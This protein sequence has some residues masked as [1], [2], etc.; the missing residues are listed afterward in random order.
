MP[1]KPDGRIALA[2]EMYREGMRPVDIAERLNLPAGTVRRW[3]CTYGWERERPEEKV[4]VRKDSERS[5][6]QANVRK[7]SECSERKVN[8]RKEHDARSDMKRRY[9]AAYRRCHP[10][11]HLEG[12]TDEQMEAQVSREY[13]E[14]PHRWDAIRP[15]VSK[16][17][18]SGYRQEKH[19]YLDWMTDDELAL[20]MEY[21]REYTWMKVF[22]STQRWDWIREI[23]AGVYHPAKTPREALRRRQAAHP[24]EA[25]QE[26]REKKQNVQKAC[27]IFGWG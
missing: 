5:Q 11:L 21:C 18:L 20:D 4:N 10:H 16:V 22:N 24:E 7:D 13:G 19:P 12:L 2:E 17:G 23:E 25:P 1:R 9:F 27:D 8:A 14:C 6:G 26:A 3:K 15:A